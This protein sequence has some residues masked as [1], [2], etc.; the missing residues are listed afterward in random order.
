MLTSITCPTCD[1]AYRV[2]AESI[3]AG[4]KVRCRK[5][6]S[7]WF[8]TTVDPTDAGSGD[9][10]EEPAAAGQAAEAPDPIL[11]LDEASGIDV[12]ERPELSGPPTIDVAPLR[13]A[14]ADLR[15]RLANAKGR[16]VADRSRRP[17]LF[18]RPRSSAVF[19]AAGIAALG[20]LIGA[21]VPIVRAAPSLASLYETVGLP[22]NVRGLAIRDLRSSE[23]FADGAPLLVV[24]GVV[25]NVSGTAIDVPRLRLAVTARGEREVYAWTTVAARPKLEPGETATFRARLASPPAEGQAI[26][27]RFLAKRDLMA[28][29]GR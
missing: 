21:R 8:A 15:R 9:S 23:D 25:E 4:R 29:L 1:A 7:E 24:T 18:P 26:S 14:P 10:D 16:G 22:V 13:A 20:V 6:L 3:G 19:A 27:V 2:P 12:I 5:C 11:S 28:A 17:K